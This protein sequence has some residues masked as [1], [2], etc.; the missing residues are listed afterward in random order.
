MEGGRGEGVG[1]FNSLLT[2]CD[3]ESYDGVVVIREANAMTY[4]DP[5][6]SSWANAIP[7][8]IKLDHLRENQ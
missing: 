2:L 6:Q 8:S 7:A 3:M 5:L 1:T 4:T